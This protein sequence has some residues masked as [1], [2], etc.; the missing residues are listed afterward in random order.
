MTDISPPP[1]MR[2]TP[3]R[4][5]QKNLFSPWYNGIITVVLGLIFL[6]LLWRFLL[7]SVL[8]QFPASASTVD[9]IIGSF[10]SLNPE[11]L[12]NWSNFI[13]SCQVVEP[14]QWDVIP[15]NLHLF[16]AGRYP[17]EQ[18]WRLWTLLSIIS[19]FSGLSWGIIA[20]N[21]AK[22]FSRSILIGLGVVAALFALTPTPIPYRLLLLGLLGL[23]IFSA[24]VGRLAGKKIPELGKWIA[25]GWFLVFLIGWW[26]IGGGFIL[27]G[28][29]TNEW[30]GL[31]LTIFTATISI[32]ICFPVG[33][34]MALG[35]RSTLPVVRWLSIAYIEFIRGIPLITILFMGQVLL[36][37]FL[38]EGMRPDRA[39]RAIVGL[40]LFSSAYLAENVRGGLQAVPRGQSEAAMALGL[41]TPLTLSLIVLPQALKAVIPAI[42][43]QFIS[44]MQDTTLL[45]I[46]GLVELLGISNSILANPNFLG[47][48]SEV[49][50]FIGFLFWIFC[51]AMSLASRW[52]ER[53][54]SR[55]RG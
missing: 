36:P 26:L 10:L 34:L 27:E 53:K 9:A 23:V 24:W 48:S 44:L 6:Y 46:V 13:G 18:Y 2:E 5:I 12:N 38:P 35:R 55:D 40:T 51:Y 47:R 41:N 17:S 50:L 20:R 11:A 37:L 49:Y 21:A 8:C 54:L 32:V 52:V 4:W 43:G 16:M 7:W 3:V 39:I 28:V 30:Q 33:V 42:V 31:L 25:F 14:A 45:A 22:L 15:R 29:S 19:L 1:E